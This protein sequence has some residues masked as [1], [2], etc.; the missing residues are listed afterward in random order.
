MDDDYDSEE[1]TNINRQFNRFDF[2]REQ[3]NSPSMNDGKKRHRRGKQEA[4]GERTHQC[5]DC[6]KLTRENLA[7]CSWLP[8]SC[9]YRILSEGRELAP[10]HPLVSKKRD[11]VR[12]SGIT[13]LI[14]TRSALE[15]CRYSSPHKNNRHCF[16]NIKINT[17][18]GI[19]TS[20]DILKDFSISILA[21]SLSLSFK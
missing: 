6:E 14:K 5:P 17:A 4:N 15:A 20:K 2:S 18:A 7:S 16:E 3:N 12:T 10:W 19:A 1:D 8:D 13:Q 11:S 9:A 21:R